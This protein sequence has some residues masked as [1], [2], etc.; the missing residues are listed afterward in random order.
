[1]WRRLTKK[2]LARRGRASMEFDARLIEHCK[3]GGQIRDISG[4]RYMLLDGKWHAE[5]E[6]YP[7]PSADRYPEICGLFVEDE[8]YPCQEQET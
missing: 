1:M 8:F 3:R 2:A 6:D 4:V 5:Y 7:P